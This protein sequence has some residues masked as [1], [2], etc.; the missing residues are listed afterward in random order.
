[1]LGSTCRAYPASMVSCVGPTGADGWCDRHRPEAD[2][3]ERLRKLLD[4]LG[5]YVA[6]EVRLDLAHRVGLVLARL[7]WGS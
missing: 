5:D 3:K 7:P 6:R 4:P 1:M 2:P